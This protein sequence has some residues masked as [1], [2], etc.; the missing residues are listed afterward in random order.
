MFSSMMAGERDTS[1]GGL[2][3]GGGAFQ[4]CC[5]GK[6]GAGKACFADIDDYLAIESVCGLEG[7]YALSHDFHV[8][9]WN[10]MIIVA[11]P[12]LSFVQCFSVFS[13]QGGD[14]WRRGWMDVVCVVLC[15]LYSLTRDCLF[16]AMYVCVKVRACLLVYLIHSFV[17]AYFWKKIRGNQGKSLIFLN[18]LHNNNDEQPADSLAFFVCFHVVPT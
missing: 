2:V 9:C 16:F 6:I 10:G 5:G 7:K 12:S 4:W 3:G 15:T 18:Y 8:F 1:S 14:V 11:F 17:K 13:V